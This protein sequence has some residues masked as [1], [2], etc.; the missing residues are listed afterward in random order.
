MEIDLDDDDNK[1][2]S[3]N[4][5]LKDSNYSAV[6]RDSAVKD[7]QMANFDNA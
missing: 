6:A 3:L 1:A 7:I 2:S 4:L 5:E